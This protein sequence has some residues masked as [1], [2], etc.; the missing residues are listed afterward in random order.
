MTVHE[1]P[2][3]GTGTGVS[4]V[5]GTGSTDDVTALNTH[6]VMNYATPCIRG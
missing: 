3:A 5:P 2:G 4:A 1:S 6:R